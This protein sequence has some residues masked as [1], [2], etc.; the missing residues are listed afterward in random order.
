MGRKRRKSRGH[1]CWSC[2]RRLPN[3]R[4]SGK[5]HAT[6]LCKRCQKLGSEELQFRSGE[7]DIDRLL[8]KGCGLI[9]RKDRPVFER[10][11]QHENDRVRQYANEII[12]ELDRVKLDTPLLEEE[13]LLKELA[14]GSGAEEPPPESAEALILDNDEL[15]F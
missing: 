4:F 8:D 9:R 5:G 1:Y 6:H 11:L 10:F 14:S 2:E 15:P 3:E 12:A 7:R 13:W